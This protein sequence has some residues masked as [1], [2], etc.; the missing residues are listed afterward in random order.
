VAHKEKTIKLSWPNKLFVGRE[1]RMKE[2]KEKIKELEG[3]A[4]G[5][6]E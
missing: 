4:A 3:Q 2:L 6:K 1:V 5:G